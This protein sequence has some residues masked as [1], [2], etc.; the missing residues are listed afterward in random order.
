M[1][2]QRKKQPAKCATPVPFLFPENI[3]DMQQIKFTCEMNGI[4]I[5]VYGLISLSKT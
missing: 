2:G 1:V 5:R 3:M 4:L